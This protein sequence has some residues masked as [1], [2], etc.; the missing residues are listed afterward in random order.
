MHRYHS[1]ENIDSQTIARS[2]KVS[3]TKSIRNRSCQRGSQSAISLTAKH[4]LRTTRDVR[5]EATP[6]FGVIGARERKVGHNGHEL[7]RGRPLPNDFRRSGAREAGARPR[8]S[9][10]DFDLAQLS[11][12]AALFQ[13]QSELELPL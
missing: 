12:V 6:N 8:R 7:W 3:F 11:A 10:D 5:G 4:S 13:L 1:T 9:L 2:R